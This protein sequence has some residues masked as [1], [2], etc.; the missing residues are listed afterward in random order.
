MGHSNSEVLK[1]EC[2]DFF[3]YAISTICTAC[4]WRKRRRWC[5]RSLCTI[6]CR[7]CWSK[8]G[9]TTVVT[10]LLRICRI[11]A[12]GFKIR[13]NE[14]TH[15]AVNTGFSKASFAPGGLLWCWF[16]HL[17]LGGTAR[18]L[19]FGQDN[20]GQGSFSDKDGF[21]CSGLIM[22]VWFNRLFMTLLAVPK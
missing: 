11:L 12:I 14:R 5:R 18:W 19:A 22:L 20:K 10:V 2:S 7:G 6:A 17:G 1:G 4:E 21:A 13:E 15:V 8:Q 9:T 16:W 3:P